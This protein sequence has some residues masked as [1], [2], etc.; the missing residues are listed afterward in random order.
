MTYN[1]LAAAVG[2]HL[3]VDSTHLRFSQVAVATNKAKTAIRYTTGHTL[4]QMLAPHYA[5]YGTPTHRSDGLFYEVLECSM[6]ELETR[7]AIRLI[8]LRDGQDNEEEYELLVPKA[9]TVT[10]LI[11]HLQRKAGFSDKVKERVHVFEVH[12][13]KIHRDCPAQYPVV[14]FN[15]YTQLY[16]EPRPQEELRPAKD[17]RLGS[18]F[19]FERE[20]SKSYGHPFQFLIK[21]VGSRALRHR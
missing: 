3:G 12:N 14:N 11:D 16:A 19:H 9:G 7:K 6:A 4:G 17:E 1:E 5:A 15:E 18:A 21:D 13:H 10:D 8:W 20:V 2:K